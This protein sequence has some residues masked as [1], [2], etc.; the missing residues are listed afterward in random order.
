L[1]EC[2]NK[3]TDVLGTQKGV[4]V[5]LWCFALVLELCGS[6]VARFE[7]GC[8]A[9]FDGLQSFCGASPHFS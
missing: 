4:L 6:T 3:K 5:C 7:M 2:C 8:F 9:S 1:C